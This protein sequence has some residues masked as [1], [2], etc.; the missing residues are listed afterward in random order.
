[1]PSLLWI[2]KLSDWHTSK[3]ARCTMRLVKLAITRGRGFFP[4]FSIKTPRCGGK[5][6][7]AL[8]NLTLDTAKMLQ[9]V[10]IDHTKLSDHGGI[11]T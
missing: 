3:I 5:H 8:A 2:A 1:M 9:R 11:T 10:L 4:G 6:E 7:A